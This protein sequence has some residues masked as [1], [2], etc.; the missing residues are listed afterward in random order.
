MKLITL[1]NLKLDLGVART[2]SD[3]VLDRLNDRA[4]AEI[5]AVVG[6]PIERASRTHTVEVPRTL[7]QYRPDWIMI[8]FIPLLDV[9]KL[10]VD[11]VVWFDKGATVPVDPE[12][13]FRFEEW[14]K[15]YAPDGRDFRGLVEIEFESGWQIT[16]DAGPP[17]VPRDIPIAFE[18][19][20]AEIV[21][22]RFHSIDA[23]PN[24]KSESVPGVYSVTFGSDNPS[25]VAVPASVYSVLA[26]YRLVRIH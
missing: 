9:T 4:S 3:A 16:E 7:P 13:G 11:G 1:E 12:P 19:A 5:E 8:P 14:G 23:D 24:V 15:I 6:Y 25:A 10:T 22:G 18:T 21:R 17:L 2:D 20:V 26:P